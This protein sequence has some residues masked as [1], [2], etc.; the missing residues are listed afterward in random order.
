MF[1]IKE[2]IKEKNKYVVHFK[3]GESEI[4]IIEFSHEEFKKMHNLM[5]QALLKGDV[6]ATTEENVDS[7]LSNFKEELKSEMN[8]KIATI[9]DGYT[10]LSKDVKGF[11]EMQNGLAQ[12][13]GGFETQLENLVKKIDHLKILEE[14]AVNKLTSGEKKRDEDTNKALQNSVKKEEEIN[15]LIKSVNNEVSSL[16]SLL[17]LIKQSKNDNDAHLRHLS[18]SV[19]AQ[20]KASADQIGQ[21]VKGLKLANSVQM[22]KV[23]KELNKKAEEVKKLKEKKPKKELAPHKEKP[24]VAPPKPKETPK[25]DVETKDKVKDK[26][27]EKKQN[28]FI[29]SIKKGKVIFKK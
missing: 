18:E 15:S 9:R 3:T 14:T 5:K 4:K 20:K 8:N 11:M 16:K 21:L 1:F 25:K 22:E 7:S 13:K 27:K 17:E 12:T 24:Q 28:S 29:D 2:I 23:L 19:E 6:K 10:E 26:P